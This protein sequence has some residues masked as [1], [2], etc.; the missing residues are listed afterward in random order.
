ME[1]VFDELFRRGARRVALIGTDVPALSREDVRGALESLDDHDV[2]VGPATDGGYY[3]LALKR[4]EPELLR[5]VPWSTPDVLTTTL[6]RAARLGLSVRVL[7]TIGDVD[8]IEDLAAEWETIRSL[9]NEEIAQRID[10]T[11]RGR[12]T[13]IDRRG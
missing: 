7:R 12:A 10:R 11:I 1:R 2:A 6:D 5:D 3:L 9:L 8:T 4:P 13:K